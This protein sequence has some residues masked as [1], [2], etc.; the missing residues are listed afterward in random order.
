MGI[1]TAAQFDSKRCGVPNLDKYLY[2]NLSE[3]KSYPKKYYKSQQ[4]YNLRQALLW[5][6]VSRFIVDLKHY[7]H[8]ADYLFDWQ[9]FVG[10]SYI[11]ISRNGFNHHP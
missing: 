9:Y 3:D 4:N 7:K 11:Y 5:A 8:V 6:K 10:D 1:I 2:I